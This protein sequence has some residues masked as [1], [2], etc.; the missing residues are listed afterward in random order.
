M[1]SIYGE[2][3]IIRDRQR[4]LRTFQI[5]DELTI[6][7]KL[8]TTSNKLEMASTSSIDE[9]S[10]SFGV[11]FLPPIMLTC[12]F[13]ASYPSHKPPRQEIMYQ[14]IDWLQ[15][16]S[17]SHLGIHQQIILESIS[18]DSDIPLLM[19][20]NDEQVRES[21]L[22][23]LHECCICFSEHPGIDF[24][25]LPCQHFFCRSCIGTYSDLHVS[26]GTVNKLL[27]PES[28]CGGMIPPSTLKHLLGDDKYVRY[29]SLMLHKTLDC[30][31]DAV[32]CPRC[33]FVCIEDE[34]HFAQ[35]SKCFFS[36]CSLCKSARHSASRITGAQRRLE[37]ENKI[38]DIIRELENKINEIMSEMEVAR[39]CKICPHCKMAISKIDGCNKMVCG[40]FGKYFC[41]LCNKPINGYEHFR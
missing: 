32:Y 12:S 7:T 23:N 26:E 8:C 5:R 15:S 25:R 21:F 30:M 34:D 31:S 22:N 28:K 19:R 6:T 4:G 35:C 20:Y 1:E 10:Y 17:L 13:P 14:W 3:V 38:N 9:F 29:E 27:C 36:F 18:P 11:Q 41:Y 16:S 40:S 39:V 2:N 37:L 33:E 24:V